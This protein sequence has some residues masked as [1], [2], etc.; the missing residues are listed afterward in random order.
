MLHIPVLSK[1]VAIT[2]IQHPDD[3]INK[4]QPPLWVFMTVG[5]DDESLFFH[6]KPQILQNLMYD[7]SARVMI[8]A[9][10]PEEEPR[11]TVADEPAHPTSRG[12]KDASSL[13]NCT[14]NGIHVSSKPWRSPV[15]V[16]SFWF[17][18]RTSTAIVSL[19]RKS[20][21]KFLSGSYTT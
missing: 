9:G 6:T 2:V 19:S 18:R 3:Q 8:L 14:L 17:R 7:E 15:S 11:N 13:R 10:T 16:I 21:D 12:P 1:L 5:C 4:H 20:G